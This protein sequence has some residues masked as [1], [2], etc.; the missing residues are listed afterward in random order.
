[1][2]EQIRQAVEH[3]ISS[4]LPAETCL[5]KLSSLLINHQ[6]GARLITTCLFLWQM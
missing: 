2:E 4:A 5:T 1:M 6:A 3:I